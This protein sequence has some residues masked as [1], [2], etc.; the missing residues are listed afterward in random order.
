MK[1]S[2]LLL[3]VAALSVAKMSVAAEP[4]A[5]LSWPIKRLGPS[6]LYPRAGEPVATLRL[7]G[8]QW[9]VD[10][11]ASVF[12]PDV[13]LLWFRKIGDSGNI[14]VMPKLYNPNPETKRSICSSGL[15]ASPAAKDRSVGGY[16]ECT[17][18]FFKCDV[19]LADAFLL[20][21]SLLTAT[22]SCPVK[23]DVDKVQAAIQSADL[24]NWLV[25]FAEEQ[26]LRTYRGYFSG[27]RTSKDAD[28]FIQF[29][30]QFDPEGLVIKAREQR[31]SLLLAETQAAEQ[32]TL[33]QERLKA[34]KEK[35]RAE[36]MANERAREEAQAKLQQQRDVR[37][38][39][40]RSRLAIG[41]DTFCG[42]VIAI[43]QP[44]VQIAVNAPL[45]GYSAE[46]WLKLDEIYPADIAG[47]KN[48][49]G[50]LTP[51]FY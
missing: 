45:P 9:V 28:S 2:S 27:I 30:Q 50:R 19:T 39:E 44:M 49:N 8:T 37:T 23:L 31:E 26:K 15:M 48:I 22:R 11:N 10:N 13:E 12:Q 36:Q 41:S 35:Q 51:T 24:G 38:K 43:R 25:S 17:S 21:P 7:A 16:N 42:P 47:C 1:K 32:K 6:N 20:V 18:A 5:E 4:P 3:L 14:V 34:E 46:P 29:Y 33:E 40:F